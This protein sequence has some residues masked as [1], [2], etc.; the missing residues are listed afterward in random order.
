MSPGILGTYRNKRERDDAAAL[1]DKCRMHRPD[2]D[3]C[4][5]LDKAARELGVQLEY[6][7]ALFMLAL[8]GYAEIYPRML[9]AEIEP[10]SSADEVDA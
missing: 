10:G 1:N 7:G 3:R 4:N 6:A 2:R 8:D 5:A 9:A